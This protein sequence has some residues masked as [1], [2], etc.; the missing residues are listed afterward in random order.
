M[1]G[2][3]M[4]QQIRAKQQ[5]MRMMIVEAMELNAKYHPIRAM[6]LLGMINKLDQEILRDI[7]ELENE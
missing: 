2:D 1:N 6:I 4:E 3:K 5:K 7:E